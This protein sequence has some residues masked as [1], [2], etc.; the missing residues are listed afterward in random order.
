MF[1]AGRNNLNA[2]KMVRG[3]KMVPHV[4]AEGSSDDETRS[5]PMTK[6]DIDPN[7]LSKSPSRLTPMNRQDIR[8]NRQESLSSVASST[9]SRQRRL[10]MTAADISN[11]TDGVENENVGNSW[12]WLIHW[13]IVWLIDQARDVI[14]IF[15]ACLSASEICCI[16]ID[17]RD[18]LYLHIFAAF[19]D[20]TKDFNDFD[21]WQSD[22]V[23]RFENGGGFSKRYSQLGARFCGHRVDS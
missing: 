20:L 15:L 1:Q 2:D 21:F 22:R 14:S 9:R 18:I 19:V 3:R 6:N 12:F 10:A 4:R 13:L 7:S 11:S 5:A 23:R 17:S 8:Q 16:I